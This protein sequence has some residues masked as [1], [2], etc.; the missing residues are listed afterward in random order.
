MNGILLFCVHGVFSKWPVAY[1]S[2]LIPCANGTVS[3]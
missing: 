2:N 3:E 1:K